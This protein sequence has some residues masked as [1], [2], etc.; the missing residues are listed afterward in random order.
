[1]WE[2]V[3][4]GILFDNWLEGLAVTSIF[5]LLIS[6]FIFGLDDLF[7]DFVYWRNRLNGKKLSYDELNRV[8][9]LPEKKIAIMI[10]AWKEYEVLESMING[11]ISHIEYSNY[12]FF[13]G[14]YPNDT[15]TL[16]KAQELSHKFSNVHLVVNSKS[17][18]T[19]KG[20]MLNELV[21]GILKYEDNNRARFNLFVIHDAEDII[22]PLSLKL[23]NYE[24][25]NFDFIQ[26]PIFSLPLPVNSLVGGV[27][28]DEFAELHTKDILV[29]KYFKLPVPSA[30]VGTA[31]SRR[32]IHTVQINNKGN[33]LNPKSVTEDYELGVSLN[34]YNLRST[35]SYAYT[36]NNGERDFIATREFF[37]R[38]FMR[39]VKQKTRWTV[40]IA[41]Q[42]FVNL[43]WR[44]TLAQKYFLFRDR[45]GPW[46]NSLVLFGTLVSIFYI[47]KGLVGQPLGKVTLDYYESLGIS[48]KIL[49]VLSLA[50][51]LF[52]LN[53]IIQRTITTW[54]V[55]GSQ[56]ASLVIPRLI[57]AN[58]INSL[59]SIRAIYQF[60]KSH[61]TGASIK[62]AK[63]QHELPVDFG[64]LQPSQEVRI[65]RASS[66]E[67]VTESV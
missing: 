20:Q 54:R 35:F 23:I 18:P 14:V 16:L 30:G 65:S 24:A 67:S 2:F 7:V 9:N 26:I 66:V 39:S 49:I 37:P 17:G 55:Y 45:K 1:M 12:D 43:G 5:P 41:F 48:N 53:R 29:R 50:N 59:A 42:G 36:E 60:S 38:N 63:T 40:G 52:M 58:L 10:A 31:L 62:W 34:R 32:L 8:K 25:E 28:I 27:Y 46:A 19:S 56:M 57:I 11:N 47:S 4:V 22:H 61:L 33:I 15:Q 13:L 3:N 44:G 64:R 51:L 21:S 6:Y